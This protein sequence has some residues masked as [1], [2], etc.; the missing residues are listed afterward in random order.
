MD[1]AS[2]LEENSILE[3]D[4]L[5]LRPFTIQDVPDV[6]LFA[7]DEVVT[8]YLTWPPH[9]D[10]SVTEKMVREIYMS[11]SGIYAIVL[12][13]E[14]KC[15]GCIDIR[16]VPEHE[17]ATFGYCLNR[18]YWN[19]GY[20]TEALAL[21]L[22]LAF[23]KLKLNRVESTHYA[24]NEASGCVMQKCGMIYEGTG[25]KEVKIK[26]VFHDVVH[27]AILKDDWIRSKNR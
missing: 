16:L 5:I 1:Y 25:V 12:K 11:R 6:Y 15:I 13:S 20:A 21:I 23:A 4:R 9:K 2:I 18:N 27:Y 22:E 14:N 3:S 17:K 7:R 10:M 24:G 8:R 26:G 19:K